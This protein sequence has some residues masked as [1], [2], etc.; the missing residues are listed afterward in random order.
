ME[1]AELKANYGVSE[2]DL[3]N[4]LNYTKH[5]LLKDDEILR[6]Y[7]EKKWVHGQKEVFPADVDRITR[8][9]A[10]AGFDV[11]SDVETGRFL[12]VLAASK[13]KGKFLE[14][15]T[16]CGLGSSWLLDGMCKDSTLVTIENNQKWFDIA[17]SYIQDN[18]AEIRCEDASN[19]LREAKAE[20]FD[21]VFA[22]A[23]PG[24]YF[25]VD[26]AIR[27]LKPGGFYVI[28]DCIHQEAWPKEIY[29]FHRK[30]HDLLLQRKDL[31]MVKMNWSVGLILGTKIA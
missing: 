6:E 23:L 15:G 20:T 27:I 14:I 7:Q 8:S 30:I 16:G 5:S 19:Y 13:L 10:E 12:S 3:R 29:L 18:R 22:D 11:S 25:L 21:M 17:K 31:K 1:L 2:D 24:K 28:D 9:A 4:V 26:E